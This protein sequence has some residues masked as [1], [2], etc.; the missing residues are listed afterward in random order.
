MSSLTRKMTTRAVRAKHAPTARKLRNSKIGS[1]M[2]VN[3]AKAASP[4][5]L[6]A[7]GSRRSQHQNKTWRST[8]AA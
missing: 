2:G 4:F 5:S 1:R 3:N 6:R 7:R 8:I